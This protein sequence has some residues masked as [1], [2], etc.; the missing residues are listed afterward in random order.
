[1][2]ENRGFPRC[3]ISGIPHKTKPPKGGFV[4]QSSLMTKIKRFLYL[5]TANII[6]VIHLFLVLVV[7]F[8]WLTDSLFYLFII[9]ITAT[10]LSELVFGY[11]V[12]S[13]WEFDL[14]RKIDPSKVYDTSCIM[15]YGRGLFGLKPREKSFT[16][17][18][19][20]QKNSFL[21]LLGSLFIIANLY[22][23]LTN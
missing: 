1:M 15:H 14:R 3:E 9:T 17:K 7:T 16:T 23:F 19:F 22:H 5:S 10:V 8:G 12:L 4:L 2:L 20:I 13:K 6:F 18:T 11:C 21:I